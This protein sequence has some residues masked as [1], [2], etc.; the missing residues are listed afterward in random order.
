MAQSHGQRGFTDRDFLMDTMPVSVMA[1][2]KETI[3]ITMIPAV[4]ITVE[5]V[6]VASDRVQM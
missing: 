5:T 1:G 6:A 4:E 3:T 2:E